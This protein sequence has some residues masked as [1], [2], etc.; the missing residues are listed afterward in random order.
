MGM[1]ASTSTVRG[2]FLSVAHHRHLLNAYRSSIRRSLTVDSS[3]APIRALILTRLNYCNGLLGGA[4]KCLLSS[5]SRVLRAAARLILRL[6]FFRACDSSL[7]L[8]ISFC[9]GV[10]I[11]AR[12]Q[13]RNNNNNSTASSHQQC[14]KRDSHRAALA[15]CS[16]EGNFQAVLAHSTVSSWVGSALPDPVL[17]TRQLYRRTLTS[18]FGRHG[19]GVCA[20]IADVVNWTS[21]VHCL[22]SVCMEQSPGWSSWSRAQSFNF[23]MSTQNLSV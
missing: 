5:L 18:P 17:Y 21:G 23:Q 20:W 3:H 2:L 12:Y 11:M 10:D 6:R 16:G 9:T 1:G 4:P 14:W 15:G 13:L 8:M 7:V 19:H 22:L